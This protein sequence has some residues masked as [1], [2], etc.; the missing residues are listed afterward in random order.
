[1]IKTYSNEGDMVLDSCMGSGSTIVA[2]L[3]EHR[4][5]IGIEIT[6]KYFNVAKNRIE[7]FV[8]E[9]SIRS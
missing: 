8:K 1:M 2:A 6:D 9:S 5:S 7:E 4:N 3:S